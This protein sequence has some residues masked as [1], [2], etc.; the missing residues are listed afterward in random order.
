[1]TVHNAEIA[2]MFDRM[3]ILLEIQGA[4]P[5]R[6]RAYRNAAR[7]LGGLPRSV[8]DML[9]EG[10][11]LSKLPDIGKD[12]AGKIADIVETGQFAALRDVE[13]EVP[14]GLV[15]LTR[16]PGLGATRVRVL[17]EE[18]GVSD[19][20]GLRRAAK[21]QRIRE[22]R[23]FGA[24]TEQRILDALSRRAQEERRYKL[25]DVEPIAN[26]YVRYLEAIPGVKE[27]I[28]A[29]SYRRR[30]ETVG[31]LDILVTCEKG[32][33]VMETFVEYDEVDA[34]VSKG[35]TRSTVLLRSGLQVDLRV[36]AQV[37][38]GAALYYFTGSKAHN[39]AVR[40]IAVKK[41]LK[42]NE[43]GVFK[44]KRRVA[45]A[46]ETEVF[47]A[48]GLHYIEPE[49]REDRGEIEAARK[50]RLPHL[51]SVGDVRGDL[52]VHTTATDGRHSLKRMAEAAK[53]LGYEYLA[54]TDH[55]KRVVVA[56]GM[57]EKRLRKQLAA[58]DRL[59]E[60]LRGVR[61]LKGV[62]VDILESGK[63]DL[64]D[65]I[66]EQLDLTVC[67]IHT[68]LGLSRERQTER[69]IR[70]MDNP[71]FTILAH[72]TGRLINQRAACD[73]DMERVMQAA[74][75]R[76]CYLELNA[77]PDR[78]DLDD[79]HC[80]MAKDMGLKLAIST[81]AH[82]ADNLSYM[83]FGVDQARRGWLEP[84]DVLN[85]RSW[86]KLQKLLVRL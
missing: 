77:Q 30:K 68:G 3:A 74:L 70:A 54:I 7:T 35:T 53:E 82:T 19:I 65:S 62:E 1:M 67:A 16:L 86:R 69:I 43:Y 79:A 49:L 58:I 75:E 76:G 34:V 46:T 56:H 12:L 83:R 50:N 9:C 81:D 36:V 20:G 18:L 48:V 71:H 72:P 21:S 47:K 31:D 38:Y 33:P 73:V 17:Y 45:G 63:L 42:I 40:T 2:E 10:E 61:V 15:E 11:D 55:S 23:G 37:S 25:A 59:N 14:A 5:F 32:S 27:V 13:R 80:R 60:E 64:S 44:G 28:V 22:L 52:H 57:D 66:L 41:K 8:S 85:T 51:V 78:L 4:N 26:S 6:V 84:E 24:K 39:I 29:G